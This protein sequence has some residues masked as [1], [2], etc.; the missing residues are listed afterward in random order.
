VGAVRLWCSRDTLF[1]SI[2]LRRLFFSDPRQIVAGY[3][4]TCCL[5]TRPITTHFSGRPQPNAP[6]RRSTYVVFLSG[7]SEVFW[8]Q[9]A[10]LGLRPSVF[11]DVDSHSDLSGRCVLDLLI[12]LRPFGRNHQTPLVGFLSPRRIVARTIVVIRHRFGNVRLFYLNTPKSLNHLPLQ[13]SPST[14]KTP[15]ISFSP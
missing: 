11:L 9:L 4:Q 3:Q 5:P 7:M 8:P 10:L 12:L 2:S 6:Q 1:V 13:S 14:I 15:W